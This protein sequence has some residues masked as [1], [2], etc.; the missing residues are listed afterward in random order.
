M[1]VL[2][3]EGDDV[4]CIDSYYSMQERERWE[5][6]RWGDKIFRVENYVHVAYEQWEWR[7]LKAIFNDKLIIINKIIFFSNMS[8]ANAIFD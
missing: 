4:V 6:G 3:R 7:V 2:E 1:E 8:H 5:G